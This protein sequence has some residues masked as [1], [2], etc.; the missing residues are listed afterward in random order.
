MNHEPHAYSD[1]LSP[2]ADGLHLNNSKITYHQLTLKKGTEHTKFNI[3]YVLK[4]DVL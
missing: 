4:N 1:D 3:I 2:A